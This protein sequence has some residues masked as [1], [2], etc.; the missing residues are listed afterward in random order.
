MGMHD[1]LIADALSVHADTFGEV[2]VYSPPGGQ[3]QTPTDISGV[4]VG[5]EQTERRP[6]ETGYEM[7][8]TRSFEIVTDEDHESFCGVSDVLEN[9]TLT[10]GSTVYGI[11]RLSESMVTGSIVAHGVSRKVGR[12]VREGTRV[13]R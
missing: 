11:E 2:V 13:S 4:I 7:V 3:P 10:Y 9:G 5:H 1:E 12:R 8:R 6:T